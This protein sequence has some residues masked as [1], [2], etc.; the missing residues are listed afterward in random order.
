MFGDFTGQFHSF[1]YHPTAANF[2]VF[3]PVGNQHEVLGLYTTNC[4][5][6]QSVTVYVLCPG[7]AMINTGANEHVYDQNAFGVT[8]TC[9]FGM[10]RDCFQVNY[11]LDFDMENL[12]TAQ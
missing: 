11:E 8:H 7:V 4:A 3:N 9:R 1:Y 5:A 10:D 2:L 6:Y 12:A